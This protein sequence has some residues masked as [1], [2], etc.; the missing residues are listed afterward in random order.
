M[1]CSTNFREMRMCIWTTEYKNKQN[2]ICD[3]SLAKELLITKSASSI[4]S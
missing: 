1:T 4:N 2:A 3:V